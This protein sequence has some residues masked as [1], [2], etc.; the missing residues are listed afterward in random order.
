MRRSGWRI[1][2][3]RVRFVMVVVVV[4]GALW[5]SALFDTLRDRAVALD[6]AERQHDNIA[7]ALA[8]QAARSLQA[9]DLILQQAA[10]LDPSRPGAGVDEAGAAELLRRYESGVPQVKDLFLFDPARHLHLSSA[11]FGTASLDLSDRSYFI[12]QRDTPGLGLFVSEPFVSRTSG[13]PT[14]VLSRRLGGAEFRGIVAAAV[15][16]GYFRR[17]YQALELGSGSSVELL[18][19]DGVTLVSRDREHVESSPAPPPWLAAIRTLG[20]SEASHTTLEDPAL[21]RMRISLRR[22][23]GYPAVVV[24]GR[25]EREILGAWRQEAWKNVARTLVITALAAILLL[26]LLRQLERDER[27]TAQ[28]HQSSKLEALGTLAGGIAHDFN[29]ILGAVLGYGELAVQHTAPGSQQ[30]RYVDNI[31]IAANRARDLVARILAFSRPGVGARVAVVL[32]DIVAEI[33]S[34]MCGS[35]P[36]AITL[37]VRLAPDPLVVMGDAA[38]LHQMIGNLLTNA[39]QALPGHGRVVVAAEPFEV[40]ATRELTVGRVRAGR[41]AR[42]LVA[43]SGRGIAAEQVERIFDPFFTTKAVGQGTG[44]GLSL[45]HGIVLEHDAALEVDSR[46]SH[47]TTFSVYLPLADVEPGRESTPLEAPLGHGQTILV[48]DDEEALV[49]LAEEVLASLGYEPIGCVGARQALG[50]FGAA[51]ESFDALLSD[52]IMPEMSG[53][54]LA[55]ELRRL[56]P[57]LPVILMSGFGGPALQM[58]AQAAGA[59]AMLLKP[60]RAVD[61]AR[62]L[63]DVFGPATGIATPA[64]PRSSRQW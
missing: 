22:V 55:I 17:F 47:G 24:V 37:D 33:T 18:R 43:D 6:T 9:T 54:E 27:I 35:I 49:R 5:L 14:F 20:A 36:G 34:L 63:A 46:V 51:P 39:V 57:T 32:Q 59:Q 50:V 30:R 12:V 41:Y 29:N 31:V 61:L 4:C 38:Q 7:G 25:V 23:P 11:A 53:P 10:L 19:A 44:L 62:C 21:G 3:L 56:R 60:L 48:V 42:L 28:L 13:I 1:G 26:A 8:E 52:V 15:A 40:K 58:R 64:A 45:V 2:G 16:I